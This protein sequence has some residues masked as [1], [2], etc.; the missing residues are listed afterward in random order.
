LWGKEG[1]CLSEL[2]FPLPSVLW[3]YDQLWAFGALVYC[4]ILIN[5]THPCDCDMLDQFDT[6]TQRAGDHDRAKILTLNNLN[7]AQ[8]GNLREVLH[9]ITCSRWLH[10]PKLAKQVKK[11]LFLNKILVF[12]HCH[13]LDLSDTGISDLQHRLIFDTIHDNS[14]VCDTWHVELIEMVRPWWL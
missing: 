8:I 3:M 7:K 11:H 9:L 14:G 5:L 4:I 2:E 6:L 13:M 1:R 12:W 10:E